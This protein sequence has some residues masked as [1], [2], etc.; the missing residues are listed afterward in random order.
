MALS[1]DSALTLAGDTKLTYQPLQASVVVYTGA[2]L[3]RDAGGELGPVGASEAFGGFAAEAVTASATAGGTSIEVYSKGRVLLTIT[4][5]DDNNDI[6]DTVY[7]SD[8]ATFTLTAS[9]NVAIGKVAQIYSLSNNQAW[10]EFE[11]DYEASV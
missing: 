2:C 5:L 11:A 10:V 6:G 8:D 3:S 7:A 9:T 1:A 4:G